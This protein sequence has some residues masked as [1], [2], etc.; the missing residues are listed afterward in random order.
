MGGTKSFLPALSASISSSHYDVIMI[1][2]SWLNPS[3]FDAELFDD[4]WIVF[5]RDRCQS[6]DH[7]EGGGVII[8]VRN[9]ISSTLVPQLDDTIEQISVKLT[10][11]MRNLFLN[12][13]Y[14]PPDAELVVY[15]N[16]IRSLRSLFDTLTACDEIVIAG[17]FNL[18]KIVWIPDADTPFIFDACNVNNDKE[19]TIVDGCSDLGLNQICN[20]E[21]SRGH[22]LDLIFV[23]FVDNISVD[24]A[25]H[26]LKGDSQFH[27]E[28]EMN[29]VRDL[30][31]DE[32]IEEVWVFDFFKGDYDA[33]NHR[34][35]SFDWSIILN[36]NDVNSCVDSLH[37][38]LNNVISEFVPMRKKRE[39][40]SRPWLTRDLKNLRNRKNRAYKSYA[41]SGLIEDFEAFSLLNEEFNVMNLHAYNSYVI[42]TG[43]NLK[44]N[45]KKFWNLVNSKRNTNGLPKTMFL[46]DVST[47]DTT[48]K[49]NLF[50][51]FFQDVYSAPSNQSP[52][53]FAAREDIF[54]PLSTLKL[55]ESEIVTGLQK[56]KSS[57]PAGPDGI[58]N[59]FLNMTST[60]L[61]P[62]LGYIFN[63][64]LSLGVFPD[65]WKPSFMQPFHKNGDRADVTNHRGIAK[66]SEIPKQF[67]K[68][69]VEKIAPHFMSRIHASQHGFLQGKSTET[70][71]VSFT[72]NLLC[73]LEEGKQVDVIYTDFQ[74]AF[75]RVDRN[76]LLNELRSFGVPQIFV[77]WISSYLT[78]RTQR[79]KL[80]DTL[81]ILIQQT[82][83]LPQGTHLG[84]LF[85]LPFINSVCDIF[86]DC[87]FLLY[88][89]DL[90][91]YKVIKDDS[92][93]QS[94]QCNLDRLVQWC[95]DSSMS[96][97]VPKCK[98]MSFH[99]K[100]ADNVI[101]SDY[102]IDGHLLSRTSSMRDLGVIM[103]P[104]CNFGQHID[105]AIV[106]ASRMLGFVKRNAKQFDDPFVTK[107]LYCSLIRP[108]LEYA[109]SVWNPHTAIQ[110]NRI[111]SIQKRFLLFALRGLGWSDP[112]SLPPYE[113]RLLLLDMDSL[114]N[115]RKA[116]DIL[117]IDKI[118]TGRITDQD[119]LSKLSTNDHPYATRKKPKF[120]VQTHSTNYGKNEPMTRCLTAYND[121]SSILVGST[122]I[123]N[124]RKLL[125][126]ELRNA[127]L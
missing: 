63:L 127:V 88:A 102:Y 41:S 67:E 87:D 120:C 69:V 72:N 86:K 76:L 78:D 47:S 33:I 13:V 19:C 51:K 62:I 60:C 80:G 26:C 40:I 6:G 30:H 44:R 84:P 112:F 71:L 82:S 24:R 34:L 103:D 99:R 20:F 77:N 81:S 29:L 70:N 111:E 2:E 117:F 100:S 116:A 28:I 12:A 110:T 98:V 113:N 66:L 75:D 36:S 49:C 15:E 10:L 94:L 38:V 55:D 7:R 125:L 42:R 22:V 4:Q 3:I 48:E 121:H 122:T 97:N 79:V 107:S 93:V 35:E 61:G 54:D 114:L 5:R 74:K 32:P 27:Q 68:M 18:P 37:E 52:R 92:D 21:N 96:L 56:L 85:F 104:K 118:V 58:P 57:K 109:S 115:R 124:K 126:D 95:N 91:L 119:L 123:R 17:D 11:G 8:A 14:I 73:N 64:S 45:P 39:A 31:C 108:I 50:A 101:S 83:G 105:Q 16:Y 89:D 23:S 90:K 53:L 25:S 106:R 43:S 9:Y 59:K 1:T 46:G 65:L